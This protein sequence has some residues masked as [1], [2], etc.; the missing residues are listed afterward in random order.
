MTLVI[1]VLI[2]EAVS[3]ITA[4]FLCMAAG[5]LTA[6]V[7]AASLAAGLAA[8]LVAGRSLRHMKW[9]ARRLGFFDYAV[10]F[11]FI[12][13]CLR[14][15]L[16][17]YFYRGGEILTLNQRHNYSDITLHLTYISNFLN[18]SS[19]WPEN[20]IY[21]GEPLTYHFGIDLFT[22]L[23]AKLGMS[24]YQA[25]PLIGLAGGVL[26]LVA[27][28]LWGGSFAAAGFL[29]AGGLTGFLVLSTGVFE[30]YQADVPWKSLPLTLLVP[31]R[32]FLFGFPA[33]LILLWSWR[34][35]FI[36]KE[37]P[38]PFW[39]EGL[40]WG[41]LPFF[42]LNT[43]MFVSL[44]FLVWALATGRIKE[45]L[46]VYYTA[47][48]PAAYLVIKMT[49]GLQVASSMF[50]L[51]RGW[52]MSGQNPFFYF[53]INF[54]I[55]VPCLLYVAVRS[56]LKRDRDNMLLALPSAVLFTVF[57]FVMVMPHPWDN[58]KYLSWCYL[59]VL[60]VI[61]RY[62]FRPGRWY[63]KALLAVF[64][65]F[66]GFVS[67]FGSMRPAMK[68]APFAKTEELDY[69]C[70]MLEDVPQSSRIATVQ[71]FNHPVLLCGHMVVAG[72]NGH[73]WSHGIDSRDREAKL[74]RI[75][76]GE[77]DWL[78]LAPQV[79]ADYLFWGK[80]EKEAFPN[81]N[82]PWEAESLKIAE[83]KWGAL[84]DIRKPSP[85]AAEPDEK[86]PS[87]QGLA[88][89][90]YAN[91]AWSGPGEKG[92]PVQALDFYWRNDEERKRPAPFS[93]AYEGE[94]HFPEAGEYEIFLAS[95]D[96]S[97]LD[98]DGKVLIDNL[99]I[100]PVRVARASA[101]FG[102]GWHPVRIEYSDVGGEAFLKLWWKRPSGKT[103]PIQNSFLRHR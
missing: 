19:F 70:K 8:A 65:F 100:H 73:L 6:A 94:I 55:F 9:E 47:L 89:V 13:F 74:T 49:K 63:L 102:E 83:N 67:L 90:Y 34:R 3:A 64:L 66:S 68:G 31:Q 80:R 91:D 84:Y 2:F 1:S 99:G 36:T 42:Q 50:W 57:M 101:R 62:L 20:P 14:H 87:G 71:I 93:A 23:F 56:T 103:E 22:A 28:Y 58:I 4:L 16:W 60:P 12:L 78:A 81:S 79:H 30:D 15:F 21:A 45:G 53:L 11:V 29:F 10:F 86:A 32:G 88:A 75:L 92:G 82:R 51:S 48:A 96:G 44:I 37:E 97:R 7:A 98:L 25:L 46:P 54:G 18:G 24:L 52:M 61:D 5:K 41:I 27:L 39:I 33:G 26:T 40:L 59:L 77:F 85:I 35:R 43:F 38:L 72:W 69:V 17:I 95:D 76:Q